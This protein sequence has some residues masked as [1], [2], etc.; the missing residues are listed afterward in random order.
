MKT[1]P[2][3][4]FDR[5][6]RRKRTPP[7]G[8]FASRPPLPG[9]GDPPPAHVTQSR[10]PH[11]PRGCDL[12]AHGRGGEDPGGVPRLVRAARRGNCTSSARGGWS[13][14]YANRAGSF[15]DSR[16]GAL[17]RTRGGVV[18]EHA[19][20]RLLREIRGGEGKYSSVIIVTSD[21]HIP[22]AHLA[23]RKVLPRDVS[24]SAIRVRPEGGPGR[25]LA[26]GKAALPR[27]VEILGIPDPPPV[28][29]R[30][31]A[32]PEGGVRSAGTRRA[33]LLALLHSAASMRSSPTISY[34]APGEVGDLFRALRG[35]LSPLDGEPSF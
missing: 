6:R 13:P 21:Y 20:K 24:L 8:H 26:V 33:L 23:F 10:P 31:Q 11:P 30:A 15:Q 32:T 12:R 35:H 2:P 3:P 4:L 1:Q 28:G 17:A 5:R 27:G 18:R 9:S 25:L 22:R 29:V 7:A 34:V 16:R 14:C 19:R